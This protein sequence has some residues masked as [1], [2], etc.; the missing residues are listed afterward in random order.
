MLNPR[1]IGASMPPGNLAT[2]VVA[3]G[4]PRFSP[5]AICYTL[6][7][8]VI[9]QKRIRE[10][11]ARF[12]RHEGALL[13]WYRLVKTGT[14][15]NFAALRTTFPGVDK[16]GRFVVF[17]VAGNHLRIVTAVH[18]DR[19]RVYIREILTHSGYDEE[20]WKR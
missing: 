13:S 14:F 7:M 15:E 10:A 2:P 19:G 5:I 11:V 6:D 12:P 20:K 4:D 1:E 8:H 3:V 9:S 16:V 17:N 18:F